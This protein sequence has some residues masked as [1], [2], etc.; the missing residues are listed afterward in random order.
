MGLRRD[1]SHHSTI[2]CLT[3][4]LSACLLAGC[5]KGYMAEIPKDKDL[6]FDRQIVILHVGK[7]EINLINVESTADQLTGEIPRFNIL[8]GKVPEIHIYLKS[9]YEIDIDSAIT[10]IP[11]NEIEQI[12]QW[13]KIDASSTG[14]TLV[15]TLITVSGCWLLLYLIPG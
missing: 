4:L 8:R 1:N 7:T 11:S 5:G 14:R 3:C 2:L 13:T 15:A 10:T 9:G 12:H 6:N